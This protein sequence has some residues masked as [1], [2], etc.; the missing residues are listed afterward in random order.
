MVIKV[1][2]QTALDLLNRA[3]Q[4]KGSGYSLLVEETCSYFDPKDSQ[5][6]CIVGHVLNYL[7]IGYADIKDL[8][9]EDGGEPNGATVATLA[10]LLE[11]RLHLTRA[12]LNLLAQVQYG[13]DSGDSWGNV[14]EA[15][16]PMELDLDNDLIAELQALAER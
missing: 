10:P 7:G 11:D 8:P 9:H 4:E 15:S 1:D 3:V 13:Q 16:A 5:P 14:V 12:A 6:L 2:Y